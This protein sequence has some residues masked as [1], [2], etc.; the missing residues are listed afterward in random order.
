MHRW[1]SGCRTCGGKINM[2]IELHHRVALVLGGTSPIGTAICKQLSVSGAR[3]VTDYPRGNIEEW[4]AQFAGTGSNVAAYQADITDFDAC[5]NLVETIEESIGPIDIIVNSPA[6]NGEPEPFHLMDK[7]QWDKT[8]TNNIDTVFNICRNLVERMSNRGFG[9]IINISS[10]ISRMGRTGHTHHAA[11]QAGIHGFTMALAQEVARKGV[12]VNTISPGYVAAL[13]NSDHEVPAA[14]PGTVDEIA[15]LVDYLCSDH[16]GY[17]NGAD[18]AI[19]GG[20]Y[21]H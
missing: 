1:W 10:I 3:V 8:I 14:R 16:A 18:I 11:A 4:L 5:V 17:I 2:K 21:M 15:S 6:L 19:N 7:Q 20:Q 12:T 9:R 13:T